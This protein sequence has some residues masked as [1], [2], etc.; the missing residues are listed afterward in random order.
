MVEAGYS[1]LVSH[2][3]S[4]PDVVSQRISTSAIRNV[5]FKKSAFLFREIKAQSTGSDQRLENHKLSTR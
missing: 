1:P 2:N 4:A 3:N 5:L